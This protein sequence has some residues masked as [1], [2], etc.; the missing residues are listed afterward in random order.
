M[1]WILCPLT[2]FAQ[3]EDEDFE[4]DNMRHQEE[5]HRRANEEI[6]RLDGGNVLQGARVESVLYNRR[7]NT[8]SFQSAMASELFI[9][10][11][12][13]Y[14]IGNQFKSASRGTLIKPF[15]E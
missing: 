13:E 11:P 8:D 12:K 2:L 3:Q 15:K 10:L 14:S 9:T 6:I 1:L 7:T 4:Q 5:M